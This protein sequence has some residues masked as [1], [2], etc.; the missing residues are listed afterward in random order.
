MFVPYLFVNLNFERE[1]P[2]R[3]ILKTLPNGRPPVHDLPSSRKPVPCLVSSGLSSRRANLPATSTKS[4]IKILYGESDEDVLATQAAAMKKAGHHV[5]TAI[6]RHAIQDA[7]RHDA[8]DLVILGSTL[9]KDDR[10]HLPYMVK[11]SHDGTKV[12]IMHAASRHH[13]V[14]AAIDAGTSMQLVLEKIARVMVQDM[15]SA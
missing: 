2:R 3:N 13:E 4:T 11:K 12:L 7:L 10:H 5:S 15:V 8:F 1:L 6:G 9:T 14:D